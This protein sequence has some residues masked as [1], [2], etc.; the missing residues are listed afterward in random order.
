MKG[1]KVKKNL[2]VAMLVLV[3]MT[4]SFPLNSFAASDDYYKELGFTK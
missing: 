1:I 3:V 2:L 4:V